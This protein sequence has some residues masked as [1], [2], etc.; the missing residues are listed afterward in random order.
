M[1]TRPRSLPGRRTDS[2]TIL[3][4]AV[5]L[6]WLLGCTD[7]HPVEAIPAPPMPVSQ[8][9]DV[10]AALAQVSS[11]DVAQLLLGAPAAPV[12]AATTDFFTDTTACPV[13]GISI[14]SGKMEFGEPGDPVVFDVRD[15][16][17]GCGA[18]DAKARV[19]V[20]DAESPLRSNLVLV[21]GET[22]DDPWL[23]GSLTGRVRFAALGEAGVCEFDVAL[24]GV[25]E[26]ITVSGT[27]CGHPAEGLRTPD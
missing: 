12:G 18:P 3:A 23:T 27:A 26:G 9:R 7:R 22:G 25:G 14:V 13:G 8:V 19:W 10:V 11:V 4:I 20:F 17:R 5:I 16:F 6:T 1:P 21:T 15:D 2:P 24:T